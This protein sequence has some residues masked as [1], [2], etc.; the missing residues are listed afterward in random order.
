M[1]RI[2]SYCEASRIPFHT[3]PSL[4]AL[5]SGRVEVNALRKVN[6]DDLLGRDQ[7]ELLWDKI[8]ASIQGRRILVTGAGGS[9]GSELCRQIMAL[10]PEKIPLLDNNEFN[11]YKIE[12]ELLSRFP[13]IAIEP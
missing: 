2:V 4:Q 5:A 8:S 11:L 7:V 12:Q 13:A 10:S 9:I 6:I 3:L 1:R